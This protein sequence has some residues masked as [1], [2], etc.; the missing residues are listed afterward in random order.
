M[1]TE[2]DDKHIANIQRKYETLEGKK[3]LLQMWEERDDCDYEYLLELRRQVRNLTAQLAAMR[4]G[5]DEE[6][7]SQFI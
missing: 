1:S 2:S 7:P 3:A 5:K 4:P 6:W